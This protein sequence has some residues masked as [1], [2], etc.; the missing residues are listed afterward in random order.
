MTGNPFYHE[1]EAIS[2]DPQFII[3][4]VASLA[5][6]IVLTIL[7][8]GIKPISWRCRGLEVTRSHM[9][10]ARR[11]CGVK[12]ADKKKHG[13]ALVLPSTSWCRILAM[14]VVGIMLWQGM[15]CHGCGLIQLCR[16]KFYPINGAIFVIGLTAATMIAYAI[17]RRM[18]RIAMLAKVAYLARSC[19]A[20]HTPLPP[21]IEK[22]GL[23]D[24][25][26]RAALLARKRK[27]TLT[28]KAEG[29]KEIC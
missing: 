20:N 19:K 25:Q 13:L 24:V 4:S 10:A 28:Q 22:W 17:V 23:G 12:Y 18:L 7:D 1:L 2:I 5:I 29:R 11:L 27:E 6:A 8:T 9:R 14:I 21:V 16:N 3:W 26:R 15:E